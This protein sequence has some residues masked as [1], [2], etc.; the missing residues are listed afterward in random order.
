MDLLTART[1]LSVV[2]LLIAAV[3][4]VLAF[5]SSFNL[6]MAKHENRDVERARRN[7]RY[8]TT[9]LFCLFGAAMAAILV[10]NIKLT[11]Q[12]PNC[13]KAV[14]SAYCPDCGWHSSMDTEAGCPAC[15]AEWDSAFCGDCGS[16]MSKDG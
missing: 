5:V 6:H 14:S 10:I 3:L 8:A 4:V 11:P 9:T 13:E 15:G 2:S 1:A 16:S 12:C 7:V